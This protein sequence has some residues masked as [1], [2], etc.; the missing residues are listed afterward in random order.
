[1]YK[2]ILYLNYLAIELLVC[3]CNIIASRN[4]GRLQTWLLILKGRMFCIIAITVNFKI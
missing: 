3:F 2:A 1:M 4:L